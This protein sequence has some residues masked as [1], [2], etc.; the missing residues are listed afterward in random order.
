M[1]E[2]A[3]YKAWRI[4]QD[5]RSGDIWD[6]H[7][8]T[9]TWHIEPKPVGGAAIVPI[10]IPNDIRAI[11]EDATS[12]GPVVPDIGDSYG[13]GTKWVDGFLLRSLDWTKS[14]TGANVRLQ[15]S[16]RYFRTDA[17]RGIART[18]E[19]LA[20]A[21]T[22]AKGDFLPCSC[23]PTFKTRSTRLLVDG[24][25]TNPP[26]NLDESAA[27]GGFLKE[28][29]VQ[30]KQIGIRL[31]MVID[32][33]S[34]PI[35]A[36]NGIMDVCLAYKG[37]M[38][39]DTF[40]GFDAG[41][42]V[43]DGPTLN[44][45]EHEFYELVMEYTADDWAWHSQ[46]AKKGPDGRPIMVENPS[47]HVLGYSEVKWSREARGSVAFNDIWPDGDLGKSLKYQALAGVWW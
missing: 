35:A 38:N 3:G 20:S 9:E 44:H 36:P 5:L 37:K 26:E 32:C 28:R 41:T 4:S 29:E 25:T 17:M 12:G 15:Y 47:T 27:I 11:L 10:D 16:S 21:T 40:L 43:C 39:S 34:L 22:L 1:K 46:V 6:V 7:T 19:S 14:G 18:V 42:V 31:R 24:Y 33:Q 13:T 8:F 30:V 23:L 45:L 2:S